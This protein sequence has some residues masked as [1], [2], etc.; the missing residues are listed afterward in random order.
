[1]AYEKSAGMRKSGGV[2]AYEAAAKE[3]VSGVAS[4]KR[5]QQT[6]AAKIIWRRGENMDSRRHLDVI[7]MLDISEQKAYM[8]L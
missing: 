7:G 1:M 6:A 2:V 8:P 4:T 3:G 5:Q